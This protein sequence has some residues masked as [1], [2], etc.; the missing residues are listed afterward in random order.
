MLPAEPTPPPTGSDLAARVE[1]SL[2][3]YPDFPQP[4]VL[5]RDL[6]GLYADPGLFRDVVDE[7]GTTFG[8]DVDLVLGLEARGFVLGAALANSLGI[9]LVLARK[10]GRLPGDVHRAGYSLEYGE[11][12]LEIQRDAVVGG[13]RVLVVDDVLA[14]GGTLA[15]A[16][17]LVTE[18][19]G[20]VAGMGVIVGLDGLGGEQVLREHRLRL[21]CTV[22]AGA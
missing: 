18:A 14:T 13:H 16:A 6:G 20:T 5:F 17:R 7:F 12:V 19:G 15:A 22:P 4:G 1:R 2:R 21:L 9:P 3:E 10:P 8:G 11:N